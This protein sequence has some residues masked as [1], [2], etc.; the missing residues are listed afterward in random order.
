MNSNPHRVYFPLFFHLEGRPCLVVG[1]GDVALRK[2][3][4]LLEAKAQVTVIGLDFNPQLADLGSLET[5]RLLKRA[6]ASPEAADYR[7]VIAT[8]DDP[9]VN[10]Q[11]Y[12][13]CEDH[14]VPVN[15][16]DQPE[17]CSVIFPAVIR[18]GYVTVA[19]GSAGQAPFL[20]RELRRRFEDY[21]NGLDIFD[22][23]DLFA[24]FR[25]FVRSRT[26]DFEKKKRL[27]EKLLQSGS[28]KWKEWAA[29]GYPH[30]LWERWIQEEDD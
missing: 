17:L 24:D 21:C 9:K 3:R 20:T 23:L 4:Q 11:I 14:G 5:C 18:K 22:H 13:D 15:V 10:L 30:D 19:L 16:V 8:T 26:G 27:Y 25:R 12:R 2:V 29:S 1:G 28:V 7:L 6:Y